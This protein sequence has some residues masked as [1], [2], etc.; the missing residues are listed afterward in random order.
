M[1]LGET[2][3]GEMGGHQPF[4]PSRLLSSFGEVLLFSSVQSL[5]IQDS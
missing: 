5:D 1:G 3:L 4:R 2:G